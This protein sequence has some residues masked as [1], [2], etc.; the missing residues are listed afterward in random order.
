MNSW[1]RASLDLHDHTTVC[2][3]SQGPPPECVFRVMRLSTD[4]AKLLAEDLLAAVAKA[5]GKP[6]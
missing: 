3:I 4:Q 1:P 2:L 5:K 6:K